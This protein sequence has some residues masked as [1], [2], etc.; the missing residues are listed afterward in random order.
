LQTAEVQPKSSMKSR[1]LTDVEGH[2]LVLRQESVD[3]SAGWRQDHA[4]LLS[5]RLIRSSVDV[6]AR[7]AGDQP[8]AIVLITTAEARASAGVPRY[9]TRG[10]WRMS[11]QAGE[12]MVRFPSQK[13]QSPGPEGWIFLRP[14]GGSLSVS[15]A[16]HREGRASEAYSACSAAVLMGIGISRYD[17]RQRTGR[18]E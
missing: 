7:R 9:E 6:Q 16:D 4:A 14:G 10:S 1:R 2:A 3:G 18:S 8:G 13:K 17:G 11:G 15:R 5:S 12:A